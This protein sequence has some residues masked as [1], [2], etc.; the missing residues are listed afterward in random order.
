MMRGQ[1]LA[2][3]LLVSEFLLAFDVRS[4]RLADAVLPS[5]H[6]YLQVVPRNG[7]FITGTKGMRL[8]FCA[9]SEKLLSS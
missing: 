6:R 5:H 8:S 1:E 2:S 4:Q 9:W 7:Q 3:D